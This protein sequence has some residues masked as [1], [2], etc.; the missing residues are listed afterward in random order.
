MNNMLNLSAVID[1]FEGKKAVIKFPDG[2]TL[3]VLIEY[4]PDGVSEGHAIKIKFGN[5]VDTTDKRAQQAK[6]LLNE[7]LKKGK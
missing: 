1:R 6:D 2:Q 4:L 5:D 3:I 7:I